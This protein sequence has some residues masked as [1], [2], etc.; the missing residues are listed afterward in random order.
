MSDQQQPKE[1]RRPSVKNKPV[2]QAKPQ[3]RK[4]E[5]RPAK[6][7][8]SEKQVFVG[9]KKPSKQK[10]FRIETNRDE[11]YRSDTEKFA[12]MRIADS[13][14]TEKEQNGAAKAVET[15]R[16]VVHPRRGKTTIPSS[17][18]VV[19]GGRSLYSGTP[20][21]KRRERVPSGGARQRR[22]R[23]ARLARSK[24]ILGVLVFCVLALAIDFALTNDRIYG[25][26][27]VGSVDV[28]GKTTEEAAEMIRTEYG[29]RL[30]MNTAVFYSS[31]EALD[32]PS[33]AK[34]VS[35]NA[36]DE[37]ESDE[38]GDYVWKI[39]SN[40]VEATLDAEAL[41]QQAYEVGRS[42]GLVFGRIDALINGRTIEARCSFDEYAIDEIATAISSRI[43]T[44]RQNY[45]V[46]IEEG[47]AQV[48][49]GHAGREV[50]SEWVEEHLNDA[51]LSTESS[52]SYVIELNDTPLQ[53]QQEDA[54]RVAD[55][56]NASLATGARFTYGEDTWEISSEDLADAI[57]TRV[58]EEGDRYTLVPCF[59][60]QE[61]KSALLDHL[62]E[63][64]STVST[65]VSFEE[66]DHEIWVV[67][68]AQG[69][70]PDVKEAAE[71]LNRDYFVDRPRGDA[72]SVTLN[73]TEIG[74]DMVLEDAIDYGVVD[75]IES[76][77]TKYSS[78]ATA[79]VHNIHTAADYIN[80]SICKAG[81]EWSWQ[82]VAGRATE[83]R[84][85]QA[86]GVIVGGE[87][88]DAVGGGLCQVATTLFNAVYESGLPV[89]ERHNHTLYI[90]TYPEGRDAAIAYPTMNLV[91][92]NDL[93]SD[94]LVETSYTDSSLTVRLYGKD[95]GYEVS[96][97][98]GER[99][100]GEAY[101]TRYRY[102]SEVASGVEY[103][104]QNGINGSSIS[105]TR[106]VKDASG[107]QVRQDVF[108]SY[109]SA[110][111][112]IIVKGT[113]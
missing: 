98:T 13:V 24:V 14:W 111:D 4:K 108:D 80:H 82:Q 66:R 62:R 84:G 94:V 49:E 56:V 103:T 8:V 39:P 30:P 28:G 27:M 92:A 61:L 54:Q 105:V 51:F 107:N 112:Q 53:I 65:Q 68:D 45:D 15:A 48:V 2:A 5:P 16:N 75:E 91:W 73:S 44:V 79:R 64:I 21:D 106:T 85:Y 22:E 3:P 38:D 99:K 55:I 43:G 74:G 36:E 70:V 40:A 104:E 47:T 63:S 46:E 9:E 95:P 87:H 113:G 96:T 76:Y 1:R 93:S 32:D 29:V 57:T 17:M 83:A 20:N 50:S 101:S 60:E 6:R 34:S 90:A 97:K 77:T 102:D 12:H 88:S 110:Q 109:Y 35:I 86:A 7:S 19:G 72:L 58:D 31:Q 10:V 69:S 23:G 59:D 42:D 25:N 41:A 18:G 37:S 89:V 81:G 67:S 78:S 71:Q 33:K 26:I 100:K 52:S 11:A